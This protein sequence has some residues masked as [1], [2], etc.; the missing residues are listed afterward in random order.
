MRAIFVGPEFGNRN[1]IL[2]DIPSP[3]A[4]TGK[5]RVK[6][7]LAGLN[8]LDYNLINGRIQYNLSPIPHI[9]GS[10][11]IGVAMDDGKSIKSGD[12][13]VIYNRKYDGTCKFCRNGMEEI[14]VNGGIHGVLDQGYYSENAS[15]DEK[16]LFRIPD[17]MSDE[18][19]VSLPIG[20]LTALHAL[21]RAEAASGERL[22]IFGGSG[23]TGIFASQIG[24]TMGMDVSVV[25]RKDWMKD[26]GANRV[27]RAGS[28]DD[29]FRANVIINSI[30][31]QFWSESLKYLD[32]GG[33]IVTFGVLTGRESGIDIGRLYTEE[34]KIVGSTGGTRDEFRE[35]LEMSMKNSYR[36]RIHKTFH[37]EH[38]QEALS[39][40]EKVRDG[41]ILI[42]VS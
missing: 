5:I 1:A 11:A 21:H 3:V 20:G 18:V 42:R 37:M 38:F 8:P 4:E 7:T 27:F 15:V 19:A 28:I 10:E 26:Y 23:N 35:L 30:G 14:C 31:S 41:R 16:N 9:P 33:R 22:M 40:Y 12:R 39:E 2:K 29:K 17:G 24:S 36:V 6:I 34:Q 13:V 25:S 32:R